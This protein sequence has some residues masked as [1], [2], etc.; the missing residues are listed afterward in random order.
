MKSAR[1]SG[2]SLYSSALRPRGGLPA[3]QFIVGSRPGA[4]RIPARPFWSR[5]RAC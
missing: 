4:G 1:P 5:P 2:L 3:G